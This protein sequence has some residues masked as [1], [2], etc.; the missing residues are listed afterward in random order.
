MRNRLSALL[1]KIKKEDWDFYILPELGETWEEGV[2]RR[3]TKTEAP[4]KM[5][6]VLPAFSLVKVREVP[7]QIARAALFSILIFAI[8]FF[9]INGE[10]YT[11]IMMAW[12][13]QDLGESQLQEI[14]EERVPREQKLL[15]V[16]STPEAQKT[17]I[18][19]LAL[20]VVPPDNRLIIPKIDKNIPIIDTDPESLMGADWKSL[21]QTFQ[22]DLRDGVVHY[23]G[24]A[25]PGDSGNVFITGHSSYYI[26]DSGRYKDVFARLN[27]LEEG[28]DI[29]IYYDQQKYHYVVRE[30]KEVQNDDISVLEQGD[31]NILTLMT[32]SPVGTNFRRLVVIAEEV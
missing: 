29:V 21:E 16:E 11:D 24:T 25:E 7:L 17:Q 22:E 19:E 18:P 20:E 12:M 28:D 1:Q 26:W 3:P 6:G 14:V 10:A 13:T 32:C 8:G 2:I 30:K 5:I 15:V 9:T 27:Q 4:V 23:P 31:E